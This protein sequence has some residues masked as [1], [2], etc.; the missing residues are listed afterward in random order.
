MWCTTDSGE[1]CDREGG[2][3]LLAR[4][5]FSF[6]HAEGE[7]VLC[8]TETGW[9]EDN[10]AHT[11][12]RTS[13]SGNFSLL[14]RCSS[15]NSLCTPSTSAAILLAALTR[16]YLPPRATCSRLWVIVTHKSSTPYFSTGHIDFARD[17]TIDPS[18]RPP[19]MGGMTQGVH[20][21]TV[22]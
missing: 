20:R 14:W 9:G 13:E 16:L 5:R 18:R 22:I 3:L 1:N 11:Q 21:K 15:S 7:V 12:A 6:V 8:T 17:T 4:L 19:S 10:E 2:N